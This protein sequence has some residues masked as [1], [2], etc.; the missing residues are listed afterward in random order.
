MVGV[1]NPFPVNTTQ[2]PWQAMAHVAS[3]LHQSVE[4]KSNLAIPGWA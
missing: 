3:V 1:W 4:G 2:L